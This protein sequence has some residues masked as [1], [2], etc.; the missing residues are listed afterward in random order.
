MIFCPQCDSR[1]VQI[2]ENDITTKYRCTRV[3][4]AKEFIKRNE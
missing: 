3:I 4:C 1:A 2:K